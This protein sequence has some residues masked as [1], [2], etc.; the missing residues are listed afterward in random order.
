MATNFNAEPPRRLASSFIERGNLVSLR[1]GALNFN[2]ETRRGGGKRE[3]LGWRIV[4]QGR[5]IGL[6]KA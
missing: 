1:V 2:A 5:L 6:R 4:L 3:V